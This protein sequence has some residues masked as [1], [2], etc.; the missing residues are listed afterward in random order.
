MGPVLPFAV[1]VAVSPIPIIAVTL[2]LATPRARSNAGAFLLGWLAGL[3]AG[4]AV[5]LAI[6]D[7]AGDGEP[8]T[9]MSVLQLV[10]GVLLISLAVR[11][12]RRRRRPRSELPRW[13]RSIDG[14]DSR[15]AATL[16]VLLSALNPKNLALILGAAAALAE[17]GITG[18]EAAAGLAVF[19]ALGCLGVAVP[20]LA[21]VLLGTRSRRWLDALR[22]WLAVHDSA[23]LAVILAAIGAKL[24]ADGASGL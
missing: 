24:L 3:S 5:A 17:A 18:S 11:S 4:A 20:L 14:I 12:W 19:V 13:L 15:R 1:G 7:G 21:Y 8:S 2:M 16:A 10:L 6:S 23:V 22:A 9:W